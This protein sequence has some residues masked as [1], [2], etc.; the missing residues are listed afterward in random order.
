MVTTAPADTL[1]AAAADANS[2]RL[3]TKAASSKPKSKRTQ[4][5]EEY[6]EALC[7]KLRSLGGSA[8][9]A[10]LGKVPRPDSMPKLKTVLQQRTAR[11][12]LEA[13]SGTGWTVH[14]KQPEV[15][16]EQIAASLR[17]WLIEKGGEVDAK[18]LEPF[19][20][21]LE[22]AKAEI[23]ASKKPGQS[24]G[25]RAFCA[26]HSDL[27]AF[28][29]ANNAVFLRAADHSSG[30]IIAD[31]AASVSALDMEGV[32]P[33]HLATIEAKLETLK[34]EMGQPSMKAFAEEM[35]RRG[36]C[37]KDA[38]EYGGNLA[39]ALKKKAALRVNK[40]NVK[41]FKLCKKC[42]VTIQPGAR[43]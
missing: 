9:M 28:R 11:F 21:S 3:E 35:K 2:W 16:G 37:L 6:I 33:S 18:H 29:W 19:Y 12:S 40:Q 10:E 30:D 27:L 43:G 1:S 23:K 14:L 8:E 41:E 7:S 15:N 25:I 32:P 26:L 22:G 34:A 38:K 36:L 20:R 17:V 39:A 31:L 24:P 13:H 42:L 4:S 5:E